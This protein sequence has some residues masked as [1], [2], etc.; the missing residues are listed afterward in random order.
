[1]TKLWK[2]DVFTPLCHSV[3]KGKGGLC[4]G[5][6][7]S[8]QREGSLSRGRG[9]CPG[10]LCQGGV[11]CVQR[12]GLC[13]GGLCPRGGSLSKRGHLCPG[14]CISVQRGRGSLSGR[15]LVRKRAGSMHPTEIHSSFYYFLRLCHLL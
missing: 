15:R 3:H 11:V 2:G 12:G 10:G 8:V 14:R 7:V 1:M 4:P 9:L 5:E 6:M 13:L